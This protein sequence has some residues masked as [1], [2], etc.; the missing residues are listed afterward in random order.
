L[1]LASMLVTTCV[2]LAPA[3]GVAAHTVN[4]GGQ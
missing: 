4:A 2:S 3:R 1:K